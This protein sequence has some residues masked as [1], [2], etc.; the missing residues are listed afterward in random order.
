MTLKFY[1]LPV[2]L[3]GLF[4]GPGG[5][6]HNASHSAAIQASLMVVKRSSAQVLAQKTL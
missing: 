4:D 6:L 5:L 1:T 3:L 2:V